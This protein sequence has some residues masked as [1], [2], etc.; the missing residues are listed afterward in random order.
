MIQPVD[1]NR[2]P[3]SLEG[4]MPEARRQIYQL[5]WDSALAC[6]LVAPDLQHRRHF[7]NAGPSG[8]TTLV[9][10]SVTAGEK[11][12][13]YWRFRQDYP[14]W[15]FPINKAIGAESSQRE[16]RSVAAV[17]AASMTLGRLILGLEQRGIGTPASLAGLLQKMMTKTGSSSASLRLSSS[18]STASLPAL[19]VTLENAAKRQLGG[20][21]SSGLIGRTAIYN[22]AIESV[23]TGHAGY[24]EAL[25]NANPE[26]A[27]WKQFN[28]AVRYIDA[29]CSRW[30]GLSREQG[31]AAI[32]AETFRP[33]HYGGLPEWLDPE[34]LLPE[35]HPLR[36]LKVQ[37]EAELASARPEWL[38]LL[39]T[40]R[41]EHRLRWL[42]AHASDDLHLKTALDLDMGR[43]SAL[44]Y[45]MTGMR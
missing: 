44:R 8:E 18:E 35:H 39:P 30:Q 12:Q 20:W 2:D 17:P 26:G 34:C 45:W 36:A 31:L 32:R 6:T 22:E 40:Q 43:F 37:M 29:Q 5:V 21:R 25:Q 15:V 24:R 27:S 41:A 7:F 9:V 33:A 13:G 11:R 42:N 1:W 10:A 3:S 19:G 14:H 16:I 4:A 23:A 28:E 38:V